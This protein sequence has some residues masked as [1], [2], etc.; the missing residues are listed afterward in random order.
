MTRHPIWQMLDRLQMDNRDQAA[1]LVELRAHVASL[2][3]PE[4]PRH[5]CGVCGVSFRRESLRDEH[6]YSAHDGP[7]PAHYVAAERAAGVA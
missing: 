2:D 5:V 4:D 6:V 1:K 3:L 7:V